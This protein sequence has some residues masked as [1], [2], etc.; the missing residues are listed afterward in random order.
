[1]KDFLHS[2]RFK[3]LV[4][5]LTVLA[6]FM[7]MAVY[8]GGSAP[9][10]AQIMSFVTVPF[11][12]ASARIAGGVGDFFDR[13]ANA[14]ALYDE[15]ARMRDEIN[16]LRRQLV[17]YE[18][19]MHENEQYREILGVMEDRQDLKME[20]AAVIA[21]DPASRSYSFTIDKGTMSGLSVLDPVVTPDG[22]VGY[23][24]EVGKNYA[25]VVTILDVSVDVGAYDSATRD[26]G[27]VSG[28]IDLAAQGLC[29]MQYLPRDCTVQAGDLILTSGSGESIFPKDIVIGTV[30][31]VEP[32]THGTST[33]AIVRP[34][35]PIETVKN[36]F[37]ITYFE[38]QGA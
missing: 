32:N 35:A 8:T 37:V 11:Q 13:Y 5:I 21:R 22:L 36:V 1:M 33:V 31:V 6:G 29:Q 19:A 4:G 24:S 34:A 38:G 12:Q 17:D 27:I 3:I 23:V 30:E 15:N 25:K 2:V 28:D 10:A 20:S 26:I 18:K 16:L 14:S 7:I 9:M